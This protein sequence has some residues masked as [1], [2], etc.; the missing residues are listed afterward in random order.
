MPTSFLFMRDSI[1]AIARICHRPSISLSH[2]WISQKRLKL[3]SRVCVTY[4]AGGSCCCI[5]VLR[6]SSSWHWLDRRLLWLPLPLLVL[7]CS[8][9]R[10]RCRRSSSSRD[11]TDDAATDQRTHHTADPIP[12]PTSGPHM[13]LAVE[14]Q[15]I[16]S[17]QYNGTRQTSAQFN[18]SLFITGRRENK[19]DAV[20]SMK[21]MK[22]KQSIKITH[23]HTH[24]NNKTV[25]WL[26][27]Q[28]NT[29]CP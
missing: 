28:T 13:L 10:R 11:N 22:Q 21:S 8:S 18:S 20:K 23:T 27:P 19:R 1:Y 14:R 17:V 9:R 29:V 26:W 12:H 7:R 4:L 6:C 25:P 3:G 5:T 16:E 2:G 24:T 15:F